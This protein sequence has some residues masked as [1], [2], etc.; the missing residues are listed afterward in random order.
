MLV[1]REKGR[2]LEVDRKKG[3][4][5]VFLTKGNSWLTPHVC[6]F[7]IEH[8]PAG[9]LDPFAGEG[10]ILRAASTLLGLPTKSYVIEPAFGWPVNDSLERI[11]QTHG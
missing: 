10:D 8:K 7:I 4:R 6:S 1:S 3:S 11:P 2:V 9:L 5:D